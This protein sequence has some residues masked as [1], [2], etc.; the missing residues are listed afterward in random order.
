LIIRDAPPKKSCAYLDGLGEH[1]RSTEVDSD[2]ALKRR[3]STGKVRTSLNGFGDGCE[4][5]LEVGS[6]EESSGSKVGKGTRE[7][8]DEK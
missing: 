3:L 6:S 2:L 8:W 1:G 5:L 7:K 4:D